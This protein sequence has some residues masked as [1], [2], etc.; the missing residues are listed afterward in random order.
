MIPTPSD[1]RVWLAIGRTDMRRGMNG[2]ALQ[3]QEALQRDPHV[4]DLF[5]F[6]GARGDLIR[7]SGTMVLACHFTPSGWSVAG[8]FG[9]RT[10]PLDRWRRVHRRSWLSRFRQPSSPISCP[11]STGVIRCRRSGHSALDNVAALAFCGRTARR[12][13]ILS[14]YGAEPQ[15]S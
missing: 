14:S 11:G 13:M 15:S 7:S 8:S 9:H 1:V 3:V 4:G 6:R 5:V 2:L 12:T 10:Q